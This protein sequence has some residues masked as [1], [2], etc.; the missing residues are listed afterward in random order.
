M[1]CV[2]VQ[3]SWVDWHDSVYDKVGNILL[4]R[5]LGADIRM[6]TGGVRHRFQSELGAGACRRRSRGREAVSDSSRR[7]RSPTRRPRIR[8]MGAGSGG[9]GARARRVLRHHHRV[10]GH[11]EHAGGNDRRIRGAG[12]TAPSHRHR[13]VREARGNARP[14]HADR[15]ADGGA[16]ST[17]AVTC[18]TTRS[19]ST[20]ATTP[21]RTGIADEQ[22]VD[23]IKLGARLEGM[24]TDPVYEGQV[25]GGHGRHDSR[26]GDRSSVEGAL[27][28]SRWPAGTERIQLTVLLNRPAGGRGADAPIRRA[29]Y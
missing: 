15:P 27:R 17:S 22:T 18:A 14:G 20:R 24:I 6:V 1:R 16:R 5:I 3:E 10:L 2:L 12:T 19:S 29:L 11:R 26:Q 8:P 13:R 7:V 25:T 4:S 23:A 28:A 21:A 9:A